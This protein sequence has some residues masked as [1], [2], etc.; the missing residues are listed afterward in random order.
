MPTGVLLGAREYMMLAF[1]LFRLD[2]H[3]RSHLEYVRLERILTRLSIHTRVV[4]H[5]DQR[6]IALLIF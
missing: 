6:Q 3:G 5:E 1:D 4:I 2:S